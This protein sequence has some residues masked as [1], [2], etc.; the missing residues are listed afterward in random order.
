MKILITGSTG[1]L[2]QALS[3]KLA[4]A[5]DVVGVSRHAPTVKLPGRHLLCDLSN[6][7]Q[8]GELI[9]K[10]GPF[11]AVV[12]TQA[13]SDVDRCEQE[14]S[15]AFSQNAATAQNLLNALA[16]NPA[17]FFYISTDYVFDGKAQSPYD[18]QSPV[19]PI[20]AYARSKVAGERI[21]L[22]YA[23]G[24]VLRPSTLFG[25]ARN[26]F[27]NALVNALRSGK[28]IQVFSDQ[29]TS[30]TYTEDCAETIA[31]LLEAFKGDFGLPAQRIFHVN[32]TGAC[33]RSAFARCVADLLGYP[34]TVFEP[35]KMAEMVRP[36]PRPAYSAMQ[37]KVLPQ[38]IGR[39]MR[40]WDE[41]L[42]AYLRQQ[43]WIN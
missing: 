14:P 37:S 2:G 38:V 30:P 6:E 10:E 31:L 24:I 7:R 25:P 39:S 15:L 40:S 18:E 16:G 1:L 43:H 34:Y 3:H 12:H 8:A 36:A 11:D 13:L 20:S 9:T 33:P 41:A 26:N 21:S 29:T 32:N 22:Q 27:C 35:V 5:H 17:W 42:K 23:R 19:N 4:V 28:P